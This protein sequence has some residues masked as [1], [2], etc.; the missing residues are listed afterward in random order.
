MKRLFIHAVSKKHL[1]RHIG[2]FEYRYNTR[3]MTDGERVVLA[4]QKAEGKRLLYRD[5]IGLK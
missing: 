1:H 4:I 5:P 2:E 3:K